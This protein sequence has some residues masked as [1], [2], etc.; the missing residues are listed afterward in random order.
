MFGFPRQ[1]LSAG[2]LGFLVAIPLSL[3]IALASGVPLPSG[4]VAA[5][6]G[7]LVV[8][9]ISPAPLLITGPAAGLTSIV[10]LEREVLG[11]LE[12]V[13][14]GIGIS[15]IRTQVPVAIGAEMGVAKAFADFDP[16]PLVLAVIS[17]SV[18]AIYARIPEKRRTLVPAMGSSSSSASVFSEPPGAGFAQGSR[19]SP[20]QETFWFFCSRLRGKNCRGS[21]DSP[22]ASKN[23]GAGISESSCSKTGE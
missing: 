23:F 8:P 6:V 5:V 2:L 3:G 22:A 21:E 14:A 11:G 1:D 17:L 19:K 9:S 7:C 4:L 10:L 20:Y 12:R 16:G 15:I 18:F 13:L